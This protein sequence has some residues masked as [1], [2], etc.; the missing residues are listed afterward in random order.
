MAGFS[1]IEVLIA[2]LL[3]SIVLLGFITYQ[4]ALITKHHYFS[5]TLQANQIAFQFLDSYPYI[6]DQLIPNN[7]QYDMQSILFNNRCK[8]VIVT[9][10]SPNHKKIQQQRLFCN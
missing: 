5:N 7:W 3:F 4:Q 10:I 6:A 2:A 1:I 9:I 8:I